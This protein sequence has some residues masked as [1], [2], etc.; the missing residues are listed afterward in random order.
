MTLE[1]R[2]KDLEYIA[3][4]DEG[5]DKPEHIEAIMIED[6]VKE[7]DSLR[8]EV[9]ALGKAMKLQCEYNTILEKLLDS[10]RDEPTYGP[11]IDDED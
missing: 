5:Y 4:H 1:E 2:W 9:N 6:L 11:M 3:S 10:M 8:S 7:V